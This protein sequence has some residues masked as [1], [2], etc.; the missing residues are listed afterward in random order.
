MSQDLSHDI[1][2]WAEQ[3]LSRLTPA[4][5]NQLARRLG[6][7][8]RRANVKRIRAQEAPDGSAWPA[9]KPQKPR[10]KEKPKTGKMY[11]GMSKAKYLKV[12]VSGQGV[13]I[14]FFGR[15]ARIARVAQYGLYD[16]VRPGGKRVKYPERPLLGF[17]QAD[18][19]LIRDLLAEWL[20]NDTSTAH[21]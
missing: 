12:K 20:A 3:L 17:S 13:S 5:R 4:A 14:G 10:K 2:A 19:E 6:I 21:G 9:R 15:V 7:E 8:L 11:V 1:D 16:E 18:R